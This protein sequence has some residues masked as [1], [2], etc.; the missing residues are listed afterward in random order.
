MSSQFFYDGQIERFV[1]Q[2]IRI[3]SGYEVEFGQDR[4]GSKTLQR[5]PIYYA[6][7]SK[8]VAA[9]LANNSENTMQTVPAMAVYISG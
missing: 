6:D 4:T 8:Q 9:I 7:G 5:V 1:V 2:F 3:M